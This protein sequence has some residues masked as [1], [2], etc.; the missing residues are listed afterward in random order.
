MSRTDTFNSVARVQKEIEQAAETFFEPKLRALGLAV[1]QIEQQDVERLEGS[2]ARINEAMQ[3]PE[4][5]GTFHLKVTTNL[6]VVL[7]TATSEALTEV[8]ILPILLVRKALI[9]DRI[10]LLRPLDQIAALRQ[11]VAKRVEDPAVRAELLRVLDAQQVDQKAQSQRLAT[12][13]NQVESALQ[14]EREAHAREL[15]LAEVKIRVNALEKDLS[16][17]TDKLDRSLTRVEDKA[18]SKWDVVIVVFAVLAAIGGILGAV[19]G[20]AKWLAG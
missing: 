18:V 14:A 19:L 1:D 6:A 7:T 16:E 9:L 10:K 3:H 4:Q 2:L 20:I 15:A 8:G 12:E 11:E 13:A 5:F 17:K